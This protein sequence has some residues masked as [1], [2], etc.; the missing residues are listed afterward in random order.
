MR[1]RELLYNEPVLDIHSF[2]E[3]NYDELAEDEL[4]K[5]EEEAVAPA[6]SREERIDVAIAET[7]KYLTLV[8][9]ESNNVLGFFGAV[10]S[11]VDKIKATE[12]FL[13]AL[14][15]LGKGNKVDTAF[16]A[17]AIYSNG[18]LKTLAS[19]AS[20]LFPPAEDDWDMEF[21]LIQ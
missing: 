10:Y 18:R 11:K 20:D 13:K 8:S 4:A 9:N 17:E 1:W 6:L 14:E 2:I 19:T 7:Q 15:D 3:L 21:S 12:K 5:P 16:L